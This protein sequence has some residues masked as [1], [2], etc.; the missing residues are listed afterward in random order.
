MMLLMLLYV[1]L[2]IIAVIIY[3][4]LKLVFDIYSL[5]NVIIERIKTCL[6][7]RYNE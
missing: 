6:D 5:L 1:L 7:N 3:I 4:P 2:N